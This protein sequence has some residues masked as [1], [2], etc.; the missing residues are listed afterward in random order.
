[1]VGK[2]IGQ[3]CVRLDVLERGSW[4]ISSNVRYEQKNGYHLLSGFGLEYGTAGPLAVRLEYTRYDRDAQYAGVALV[5]RS[6]INQSD[7]EGLENSIKP[8]ASLTSIP[9]AETK[10]PVAAE[11]VL[12][13]MTE[14]VTFK[15]G[16]AGLTS[17]AELTLTGLA[18]RLLVSPS[19]KLLVMGHTDN[20]GAADYNLKLSKMRVDA[21]VEFLVSQGLNR[22]NLLSRAYGEFLPIESNDTVEGR[23]MN[24]RVEFQILE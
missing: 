6:G 4:I 8:L 24:R 14:A 18:E 13:G 22:Q 3:G 12:A 20:Q 11:K 2:G 23:A 10:K 17:S 19:I 15:T 5:Y 16:Q 21:V 9:H 7:E 1:M